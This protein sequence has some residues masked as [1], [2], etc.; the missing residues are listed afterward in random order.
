M[1]ALVSSIVGFD[2]EA[3][4]AATIGLWVVA[5]V[6]RKRLVAVMCQTDLLL[7]YRRHP[8]RLA[9]SDRP[10]A[11]EVPL[12]SCAL[13]KVLVLEPSSNYSSSLQVLTKRT[14]VFGTSLGRARE[15]A[16]HRAFALASDH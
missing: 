7:Y 10:G 1:V 11:K 4:G 8:T 15:P 2:A 9:C 12:S 13:Q 6:C 3:R 14:E 16:H 5:V